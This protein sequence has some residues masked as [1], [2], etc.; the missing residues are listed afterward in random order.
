MPVRNK[1]KQQ[2]RIPVRFVGGRLD[3]SMPGTGVRAWVSRIN[4][5]EDRAENLTRPFGEFAEYMSRSIERNFEAEGRPKWAGLS[6]A[7]GAWKRKHFP[8]RK[9][10]VL[11]GRLKRQA[12]SRAAWVATPKT[13]RFRPDAPV[14][15]GYD[16]FSLHQEGTSKM[17][18]RVVLRLQDRDKGEF[19]KIM[20][21]WL[22]D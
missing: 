16:L 18:A 9:L 12:T 19:T 4:Q 20:R 6:P 11:T 10:L 1:L 5:F 15:G 17:P 13:L 21:R 2:T 7:Y 3:V 22:Y 8:G 14:P